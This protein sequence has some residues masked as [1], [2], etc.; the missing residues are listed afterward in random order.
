[1]PRTKKI[2]A[3]TDDYADVLE[4]ANG[5]L[6]Q[7][8]LTKKFDAKKKYMFE[9]ALEND[10]R[11]LPIMMVQN[12]KATVEPHKKWKPFQNLVYT[13]QIVWNGER[14]AIRYYDGCTT[15]FVDEQPKDKDL[16]D[17][18][19]KSTK[20]RSFLEGK[21]GCHGDER[22]LLLYLYICSWNVESPFRTRTASEV[23]R[24]SDADSTAD[25]KSAKMDLIE[26]ALKLAREASEQK[27]KMH[28]AYLEIPEI[29]YE[30]GNEW[31]PKQLRTLYREKAAADPKTF[32]ESYGNKDLEVKWLIKTALHSGLI[33]NKANKNKQAWKGSGTII[34]DTSGINSFDGIV[35]ALF[36]H[37][38][39][40]AGEEFLIQLRALNS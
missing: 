33:N 6:E 16:I 8:W 14:R 13:S 4:E 28:A 24:P 9:L 2:A 30:S 38:K 36:E 20:R 35:N 31:T 18:F 27:V 3:E 37:A 17:G 34:L 1:M 10:I 29:D 23:F 25:K 40:E 19:M 15:L 22:M 12:N 26:E 32:I 7:E 11:E 39:S 21:F 5:P